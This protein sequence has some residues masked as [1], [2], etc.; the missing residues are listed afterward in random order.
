MSAAADDPFVHY[1]CAETSPAKS[2][3][4]VMAGLALMKSRAALL[5]A[6]E[7]AAPGMQLSFDE[8]AMPEHQK[9]QQRVIEEQ[10]RLISMTVGA[11]GASGHS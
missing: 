9:S 4:N 6:Q 5:L 10:Q 1:M 2:T 8:A 3:D 11:M 7:S